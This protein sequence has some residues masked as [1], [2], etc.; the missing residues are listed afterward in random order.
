ML[1]GV[2]AEDD[3]GLYI[4]GLEALI[5]EDDSQ[6]LGLFT[7]FVTQHPDSEYAQPARSYI[8]DLSS[9][10]DNSG[11][12]A[13]YLGN[14]ATTS[15]TAFMIPEL[16]GSE[17]DPLTLGLSGIGGVG[18]GIGGSAL[19]S[20]DTEITSALSWW[21]T[22]AQ[23][24]GL[25][26]YLYATSII[27]VYELFAEDAYRVTLGGRLAVINASRF[28]TY[29]FARDRDLSSGRASFVVQSYLWANAYYWMGTVI[30]D[31]EDIKLSS[32]LGLAVTDAAAA[33]GYLFWDRLRWTPLRTGLVSVG[34]L[35]GGLLGFFSSMITENYVDLD[36]RLVLAII[37]TGAA[38]GQAAGV[39]LTSG[40]DVDRETSLPA[41]SLMPLLSPDRAGVLVS[42]A[43]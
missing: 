3:P 21:M 8:T 14:L 25:G 16:L 18:A 22:G 27:D 15:Y 31:C 2:Q 20:R 35:G 28:G 13:F 19:L 37:M 4:E 38:A 10:E 12:V 30:A 11:I 9:R 42:M 7:T 41:I 39:L 24:I 5:R 17:S 26:N 40:M 43:L 6:A 36:E 29:A 34:G 1:P 23:I 33:A 32:S